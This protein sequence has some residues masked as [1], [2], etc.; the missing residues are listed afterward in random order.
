VRKA[1]SAVR[2]AADAP[3]DGEGRSVEDL[4]AELERNPKDHA[5]RFELANVLLRQEDHDAAVSE[6]LHII[7]WDKAFTV[8]GAEGSKSV[9]DF[10]L[11]IFEALGSDHD[12]TKKGR[13]RL[14]NIL[15]M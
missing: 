15:L 1:I 5:T 13:R 4:R 12:V 8:E 2:L 6:L 9:R 3:A 14:A 10:T 11:Q 7:K